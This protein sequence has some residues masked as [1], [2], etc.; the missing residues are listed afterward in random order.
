MFVE[1]AVI[2]F[3]LCAVLSSGQKRNRLGKQFS[4]TLVSWR[5]VDALHVFAMRAKTKQIHID[6]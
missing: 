1:I 4:A 5:T 6:L 2:R 3:Q